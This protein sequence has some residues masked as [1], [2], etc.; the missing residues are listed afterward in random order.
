MLC[1]FFMKY[2]YTKEQFDT[3]KRNFSDPL[4]RIN[5]LYKIID[6]QGNQN[7]LKLNWAQQDLYKNMWY[8]NIVLKARQLGLSTFVSLLFL[9]RCFFNNN[10][11]AGIIA[12]TR[13]D[14]EIMFRRVKYAYDCLPEDLKKLRP[15]LVDTA[16]E[17]KFNNGSSLRVA[18]SMRSATLNYLH[19][20]EFGK[21]CAHHP[22]KAQEIITGSLNTLAPGQFCFIES[23]AEGRGSYF[24]DMCQLAQ[25]QKRD[26]YKLTNLDFRFHFF[27]WWKDPAY[28]LHEYVEPKGDIKEYF[29][30]LEA[31]DIH[32]EKRIGNVPY[33]SHTPVHTAWDLGIGVVGYAA[34]WFFQVCGNEIHIIDFFQGEG[35]SLV[36]LI[37]L[38]KSKPYIYGDHLMPHDIG[39]HEFSYG[40]SRLQVAKSLGIHPII[41]NKEESKPVLSIIEGIEAVKRIFPR[42]WFD[43]KKC[44]EGLQMLENY[45]KEW[46]ERLC[47]WGERAVKDINCHASDAFRMLSVGLHKL[48]NAPETLD[49]DIKALHKYWG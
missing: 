15:A 33:D 9:D 25:Q 8:C 38:V 22:E 27:P 24:Y 10:M 34:I 18:T 49:K 11:N 1:F 17:L 12:H 43:E 13:E 32:H 4:W 16:R 30:R 47:K 21:I 6:K 19:I 48:S 36:E 2:K 28:V 40:H 5:H 23:T 44:N 20:S 3:V 39:V 37:A 14:A 41:A 42:C 35:I 29:D 7:T 26:N 46:D 45:H 31:K